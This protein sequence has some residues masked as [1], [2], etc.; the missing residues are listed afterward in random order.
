MPFPDDIIFLSFPE[1]PSKCYAQQTFQVSN[2]LL[3][4]TYAINA[5]TGFCS[6]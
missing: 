1:A 3:T 6:L 4:T 5:S 2:W